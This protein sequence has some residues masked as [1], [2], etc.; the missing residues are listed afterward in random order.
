MLLEKISGLSLQ[1]KK[2]IFIPTTIPFTQDVATFLR[3]WLSQELPA[4]A[5]VEIAECGKYL[6]IFVGPGAAKFQWD[7]PLAKFQQRATQISTTAGGPMVSTY[8]YNRA[9]VPILG[10]VGQLVPPPRDLVSIERKILTHL[11]L[12]SAPLWV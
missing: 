11:R 7:L 2:T 9:A 5:Q 6:G 10:Y 3:E 4:W 8:H 12:T 1:P